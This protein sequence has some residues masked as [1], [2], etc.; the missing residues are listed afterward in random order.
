MQGP[1]AAQD[2][3]DIPSADTKG[4][5][6]LLHGSP[7]RFLRSSR[8]RG[9]GWGGQK[10][11][12]AMHCVLFF[13]PGTIHELFFRVVKHTLGHVLSPMSKKAF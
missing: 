6:R 2:E 10:R 8:S 5:H 7:G 1:H 11:K 13:I 9:A 4:R 3:H 12:T